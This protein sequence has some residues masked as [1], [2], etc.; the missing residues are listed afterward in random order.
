MYFFEHLERFGSTPALIEAETGQAVSYVDLEERIQAR[1][2]QLPAERQLVFIEARNDIAS[3]TSY[4]ACLR[5]GHVVYLLESAADEKSRAL[6]ALYEPNL[7][8]TGDDQIRVESR[9]Q[10]ALHPELRLLLSTSGSTGIPKF[11]KLSVTNIQSN[12]ASIADYL[13]IGPDERAY[14]HLKPFYS[15]G[16]SVINSHLVNGAALILSSRSITDAEF[17]KQVQ[18]LHATS[19][20]G[21]PY[22]FETLLHLNFDI[23]QYPHLRTL[24]QAGGRLEPHLV[25]DYAQRC[26]SAGKHFIVMYGQTEAAPRISYL[27]EAFTEKYPNSIGIAI[28]GGTLSVVDEN[29]HPIVENDKPGELTYRGPNVMMGYAH[30]AEQLASDETP[31]CLY[32]GDIAYR[33]QDGLFHIVGRTSR[34]VKLFGLRINLDHVQSE[35]KKEYPHVAVTGNDRFIGI[36]LQKDGHVDPDSIKKGLAHKYHLPETCFELRTYRELPLLASGKY[37]FQRILADIESPQKQGWLSRIVKTVTDVLELNDKHWESIADI[38]KDI[39]ANPNVQ[40]SDS[41]ESLGADSLSYVA[42]SIE[43]E[44]A[45]GK[46]LPANWRQMSVADLEELYLEKCNAA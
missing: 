41:F 15:Y 24:T 37:N 25:S 7:V 32:T 36:A 17:L 18:S 34:F 2:R 35:L 11:V 31:E 8:I 22:T 29:K 16:I 4:L 12:A 1:C 46:D 26:K 19:I 44:T 14:A 38:Y 30:S 28:P 39:L 13:H 9:R 42:L 20:A 45:L 23:S 3:I 27:P 40:H 6:V 33:N 5:L 21:V 10:H 43:M